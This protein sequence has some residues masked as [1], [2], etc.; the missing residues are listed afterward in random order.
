MCANPQALEEAQVIKF[1]SETF[2]AGL[3]LK[4]SACIRKLLFESQALSLQHLRA[5]VEPPSLDAPPRKM[6]VAERLAREKAQREKL[7]GLIWGPE[8]QP[9]Q[10]IVDACV[11]MLEQFV[12]V[13]YQPPH[14][15]AS[16]SQEIACV[17]RDKSVLADLDG[18]LKIA[19][20]DRDMSC[21]A[22]TEYA[23][24][25]AW[26]RRSLAFDLAG[27]A[28]FHALEGW[29]NRMFLALSHAFH[30]CCGCA[31]RVADFGAGPCQA[32]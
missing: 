17:K 30:P 14:K 28:S 19:S 6:P 3:T 27:L 13:Y 16:R 29:V 22:S 32:P 11:D 1:I 20:K 4:Q 31:C 7:N 21:D 23:L 2:P 12:L 25:Q 5:R 26:Q 8:M 9:G 15:F 10:G 18:G 24:R